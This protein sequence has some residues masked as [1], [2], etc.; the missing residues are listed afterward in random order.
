MRSTRALLAVLSL[1]LLA[2]CGPESRTPLQPVEHPSLSGGGY[3]GSSNRSDSTGVTIQSTTE[4]DSTVTSRGGGYM[5]N[6]A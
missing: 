2:A 4:S 3:V 6:G 5:G 1:A